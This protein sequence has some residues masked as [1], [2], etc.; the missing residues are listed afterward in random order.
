MGIIDLLYRCRYGQE[1]TSHDDGSAACNLGD[2]P[3]GVSCVRPN[4]FGVGFETEKLQSDYRR[5][6]HWIGFV[7]G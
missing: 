3:G 5:R 2:S 1:S 6:I 4:H 7:R